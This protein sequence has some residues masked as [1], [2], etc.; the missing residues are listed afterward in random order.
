MLLEFLSPLLV[1]L[2]LGS[3]NESDL[4]HDLTSGAVDIWND[5][6]LNAQ[7]GEQKKLDFD[8][9]HQQES[10]A[11]RSWQINKLKDFEMRK[12]GG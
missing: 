1:L 11:G 9:V 2:D 4:D 3:I 7:K 6:Q 8:V 10:F 5:K 12:R